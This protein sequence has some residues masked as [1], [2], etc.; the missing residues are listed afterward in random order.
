LNPE[1]KNFS[2]RAEVAKIVSKFSN[3]I[4]HPIFLDGERTNKLTALWAKSKND[5]EENDYQEFWEHISKS[6]IP[7]KYLLHY[8]AEMPLQVKS[9][10]YFPNSHSE[11]SGM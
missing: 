11:R 7:F 9:I 10:L 3:F 1:H 5:I 6:K 8:T 2:K 4:S